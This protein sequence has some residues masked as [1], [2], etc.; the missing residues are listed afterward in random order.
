MIDATPQIAS[1]M[2]SNSATQTRVPKAILSSAKMMR[3]AGKSATYPGAIMA[4]KSHASWGVPKGFWLRAEPEVKSSQ[5]E[6]FSYSSAV[7][8]Q[9]TVSWTVLCVSAALLIISWFVAASDLAIVGMVLGA[10]G[11][12][13]GASAAQKAASEREIG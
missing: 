8:T 9:F 4:T 13:V 5:S 12:F 7:Y 2:E 3:G 11:F 1:W 6:S 10:I